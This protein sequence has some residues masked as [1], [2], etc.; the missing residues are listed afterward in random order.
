[1]ELEGL[2]EIRDEQAD[3]EAFLSVNPNDRAGGLA[4][5]AGSHQSQALKQ[6]GK[7]HLGARAQVATIAL[8]LWKSWVNRA[9]ALM[10][11]SGC[12]GWRERPYR[13]RWSCRRGAGVIGGNVRAIWRA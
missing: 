5:C 8:S 1:M 3:S 7:P 6:A 13:A 10:G 2:H 4:W 11:R 9:S 12:L